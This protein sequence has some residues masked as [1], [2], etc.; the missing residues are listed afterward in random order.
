[1][2]V[3]P[4]SKSNNFDTEP[5][6]YGCESRNIASYLAAGILMAGGVLLLTGRRRAGM[7]AASTG[8]ALALLDQKET[9]RAW[10]NRVPGY[11]D[12]AERMLNQVQETL[13]DIAV[14]QERIAHILD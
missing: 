9:L 3:V 8:T 1:M 5:D 2:V 11:L 13:Q 10:W 12:Q 14:N 4:L 7:V 6:A